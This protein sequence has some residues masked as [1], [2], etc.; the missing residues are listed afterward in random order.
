M[1]FK[2]VKNML[3]IYFSKSRMP[4]WFSVPLAAAPAVADRAG[5]ATPDSI[6]SIGSSSST[7][8]RQQQQLHQQQQQ[9]QIQPS[10]VSQQP[11]PAAPAQSVPGTPPTGQDQQQ[12]PQ[13][14]IG[15]CTVLGLPWLFSLHTC[16]S[17]SFFCQACS[18]GCQACSFSFKFN[19]CSFLS[20]SSFFL[21]YFFKFLASMVVLFFL[22]SSRLFLYLFFSFNTYSVSLFILF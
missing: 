14:G 10:A 4:V 17:L 16:S 8:Q 1:L 9:Q 19:I 2:E 5:A 21:F 15:Q 6:S 12:H 11:S 7:Q 13:P 18:F 20:L 3:K 22:S